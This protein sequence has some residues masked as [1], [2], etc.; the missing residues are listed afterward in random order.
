MRSLVAAFDNDEV[1]ILI[2]S[3]VAVKCCCW[4]DN[5]SKLS[6]YGVNTYMPDPVVYHA[7]CKRQNEYRQNIRKLRAVVDDVEKMSLRKTHSQ[8]VEHSFIRMTDAGIM[9]PTTI[10]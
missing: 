4:F 2:E 10:R 9:R 1:D 6:K 5:F 7:V 3:L 8:L